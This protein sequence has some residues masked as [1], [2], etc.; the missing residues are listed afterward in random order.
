MKIIMGALCLKRYHLSIDRY[1]IFFISL[2]WNTTKVLLL[3][4]KQHIH[5]PHCTV[6]SVK[7]PIKILS[8]CVHDCNDASDLIISLFLL[9][10]YS[11]DPIDYQLKNRLKISVFFTFFYDEVF[12]IEPDKWKKIVEYINPPLQ[13]IFRIV[14]NISSWFSC[15]NC[16]W[17]G[18]RRK[19]GVKGLLSSPM[20]NEHF[21]H[22][23]PFPNKLEIVN[24]GTRVH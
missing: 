18:W 19:G 3:S 1:L 5:T 6:I 4:Q 9:I 7:N 20:R 16:I 2:A 10:C 22:V 21:W 24:S 13:F 12:T 8:I 17:Q 14:H 15:L 23:K 11:F